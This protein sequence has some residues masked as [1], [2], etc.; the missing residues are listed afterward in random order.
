MIGFSEMN[1][2]SCP[3][4]PVHGDLWSGPAL[5]G[6]AVHRSQGTPCWRLQPNHQ[7]PHQGGV[8]GHCALLQVHRWV[9]FVGFILYI[10][11]KR[12]SPSFP[13]LQTR[14]PSRPNLRGTSRPSSWRRRSSCLMSQSEFSTGA[15]RFPNIS[16]CWFC[17]YEG[18]ATH[19]S[20]F[21]PTIQ[22]Y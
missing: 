5:Q 1:R 11:E 2:L 21:Y 13:L 4:P 20:I 7:T 12:D 22:P 16:L 14:Y 17:S 8:P 19:T 9:N 3:P 10:E 15:P 6:G 18:A